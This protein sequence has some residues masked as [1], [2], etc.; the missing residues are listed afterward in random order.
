MNYDEAIKEIY[1]NH[2]EL[3]MKGFDYHII[4]NAL[5]TANK[6]HELLGLYKEK[7]KYPDDSNQCRDIYIKIIELEREL[8]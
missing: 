7:D 1:D 3:T 5:E 8:E 4:I 2:V 6:E